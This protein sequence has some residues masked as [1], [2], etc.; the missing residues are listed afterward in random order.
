MPEIIS[1]C[2]RCREPVL[3][4]GYCIAGCFIDK[5]DLT[6]VMAFEDALL[7]MGP[8]EYVTLT[9]GDAS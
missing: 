3:S 8:M 2:V 1:M 7:E 6:G 9:N 5:Y 4:D